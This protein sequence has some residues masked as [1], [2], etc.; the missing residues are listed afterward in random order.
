MANKHVLVTGGAGYVGSHVVLALQEAGWI[1]AILDNFSTG[2]RAL[3]PKGT[4][5]FEG[6]VN[7][8]DLVG[9]I[10][11]DIEPCAVLH[12]AGSIVVPESLRNPLKYYRNNTCASRDLIEACISGGVRRFIFSSSAAIYGEPVVVPVD[13]ETP[14]A[15][16]NPYGHSKRMTEIMLEAVAAAS[17]FRYI[18]LRYFNVAGADPRGRS[19]QLSDGATHLLKVACEVA[20]GKRAGLEIFGTDYETPDGTCIRDYIHV[21]DLAQAHVAALEDLAI[22]GESLTLNCGYGHGYSVREVLSAVEAASGESLNTSEGSRR[23]G[24]MPALIANNA[25]LRKRLQWNPQYDDLSEIVR[26]ALAWERL[27][28]AQ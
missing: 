3:V 28:E 13:E 7:D 11:G 22:N 2:K 16:M 15:P 19:G 25:R 5:L 6:N 20:T 10:L 17:D 26:T 9:Q 18:S 14:A 1:P 4:T 27:I 23:P 12:F 21:S 8:T 24:D